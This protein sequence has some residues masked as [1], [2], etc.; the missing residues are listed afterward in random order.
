MTWILAAWRRRFSDLPDGHRT[1]KLRGNPAGPL[2]GL[3]ARPRQGAPTQEAR[4][5]VGR[6]AGR[7]GRAGAA[8]PGARARAGIPAA[9]PGPYR[10][11][12][13]RPGSGLEDSDQLR[14]EE[15]P[16]AAV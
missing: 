7:D 6:R 9:V 15:P 3:R 8:A 11:A 10:R 2:V 16:A 4:P 12:F 14:Q 13:A 1:K 5:G